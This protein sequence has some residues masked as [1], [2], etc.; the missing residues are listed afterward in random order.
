MNTMPDCGNV[1]MSIVGYASWNLYGRSVIFHITHPPNKV[2][3]TGSD[4]W[5]ARE[6]VPVSVGALS[7]GENECKPA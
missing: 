6:H 4:S 3:L 7:E 5:A 2:S 1:F